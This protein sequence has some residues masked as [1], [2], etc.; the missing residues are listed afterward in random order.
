M[1]VNSSA[2]RSVIVTGGN[3]GLG[4]QTAKRLAADGIFHVII[5]CR[6]ADRGNQAAAGD[7]A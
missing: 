2:Q 3:A 7:S 4:D 6:D 5:T 1:K